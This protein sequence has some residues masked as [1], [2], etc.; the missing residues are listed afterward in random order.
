[1]IKRYA[2]MAGLILLAAIFLTP[3]PN[4]GDSENAPIDESVDERS[5]FAQDASQGDSGAVDPG[6]GPSASSDS[7]PGPVTIESEP[8]VIDGLP[9][10][11]DQGLPPPP[12]GA[13]PIDLGPP[14]A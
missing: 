4:P 1:M 6:S 14:P 10:A 3:S 5:I 9:V 2:T 11:R 12:D 7:G 13:Q 8:Q